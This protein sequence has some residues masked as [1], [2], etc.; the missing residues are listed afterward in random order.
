MAPAHGRNGDRVGKCLT[1]PVSVM[2][3]LGLPLRA[4]TLAI[5]FPICKMGVSAMT[6]RALRVRLDWQKCRAVE[7]LGL[8]I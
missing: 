2:T 6:S 5:S 3:G 8:Y 1:C 7:P 4:V